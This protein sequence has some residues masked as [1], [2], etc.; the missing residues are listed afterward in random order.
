MRF[1]T[2]DGCISLIKRRCFV[3]TNVTCDLF[4]FAGGPSPDPGDVD[5]VPS[6]FVFSKPPGSS[7]ISRSGR[8]E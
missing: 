3:T 6:I 5:Y 7:T 8:M 1:E 2:L 4:L